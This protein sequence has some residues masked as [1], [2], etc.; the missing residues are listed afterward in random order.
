MRSEDERSFPLLVSVP[1]SS[2]DFPVT[3]FIE[4]MLAHPHLPQGL[5]ASALDLLREIVP[6]ERDLIMIVVE[7]I[8]ELREGDEDVENVSGPLFCGYDSHFFYRTT[9]VFLLS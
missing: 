5:I 9:V 6:S 1:P 4:D 7:I 2:P 8:I 3:D